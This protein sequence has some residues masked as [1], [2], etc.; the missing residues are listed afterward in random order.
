MNNEKLE[1]PRAPDGTTV[2]QFWAD[3]LPE[4]LARFSERMAGNAPGVHTALSFRV[5]GENGGDWSVVIDEG[6]LSVEQGLRPDAA[7]T[8]KL[9]EQDFLDA[10]TGKRDD[11]IP[12]RKEGPAMIRPEKA[13]ANLGKGVANLSKMSGTILFRATH[14]DGDFECLIHLGEGHSEEPTTTITADQDFLRKMTDPKKGM[15][16]GFITGKIKI[17]GSMGMIKNLAK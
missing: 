16:K 14:A 1:I 15:M 7:L 17:K 9:S 11:L 5:D 12:G 8:L 13:A 3:W 10:V 4:V 6:K 2:Q